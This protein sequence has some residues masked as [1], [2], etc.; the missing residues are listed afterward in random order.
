MGGLDVGT[1]IL[2][3]IAI[4]MLMIAPTLSCWIRRKCDEEAN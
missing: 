2:V 1:F 3:V 4:A